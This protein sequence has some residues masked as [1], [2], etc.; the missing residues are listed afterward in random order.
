MSAKNAELPLTAS[1]TVEFALTS[2]Q[3]QLLEPLLVLQR[4]RDKSVIFSVVSQSYVPA[5]GA[6][7]LRLQFRIVDRKTAAKAIKILRQAESSL[8]PKI[9]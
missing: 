1:Q 9:K 3:A 7:V 4:C 5:V 6:G 2:Q 8:T